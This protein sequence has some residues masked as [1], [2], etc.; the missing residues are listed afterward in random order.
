MPPFDLLVLQQLLGNVCAINDDVTP[1][2]TI[3]FYQFC[4]SDWQEIHFDAEKDKIED[5]LQAN[6]EECQ[7][8]VECFE[9][10]DSNSRESLP[11]AEYASM[12]ILPCRCL[13]VPCCFETG[14]KRLD[15]LATI[16]GDF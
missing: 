15:I 2:L 7:S 5:V 14:G 9:E 8:A 13:T 6:I 10:D 3:I 11:L 12:P 4:S 1:L 16:V